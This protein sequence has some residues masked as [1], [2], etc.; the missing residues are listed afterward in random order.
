MDF[1]EILAERDGEGFELSPEYVDRL[2][3]AHGET[4]TAGEANS[5][6][7][8]ELETML[9]AKD[10]EIARLKA[11]NADLIVQLPGDTGSAEDEENNNDDEGEPDSPDISDL[12]EEI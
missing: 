8:A 3:G 9:T 6:R 2:A 4:V 1:D 10:E 7:I 5:G 12:F 11:E